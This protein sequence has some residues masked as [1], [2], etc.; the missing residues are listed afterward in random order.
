M[1]IQYTTLLGADFFAVGAWR[2][3][4]AGI[5]TGLAHRD[6]GPST[7]IADSLVRRLGSY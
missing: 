7:L 3:A 2:V 1:H 5:L 6:D 4:P